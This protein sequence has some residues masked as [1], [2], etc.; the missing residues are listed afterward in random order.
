PNPPGFTTG[1]YQFFAS[2][3]ATRSG[4]QHLAMLVENTPQ[5]IVT[6]KWEQDALS[7]IGYHFVFTDTGLS[8]T[9]PNFNG[10]VQ[11]MKNAGVTGV[12]FQATGQILGQLANAMNQAG[13]TL[14]F[15]NYVSTAYDPAFIQTAGPGTAG[16]VLEQQ[17]AMYE[18]QDAAAVP[19][20][21]TFDQWYSRVNPGQ[22]PDIYAAYGWLA[23]MLFAEGLNAGGAP[24][25]PALLRGLQQITSFNGAGLAAPSDPVTK[26]PPSCWIAIDVSNGKFVRD[27]ATPSGFRCSPSGYYREPG[28]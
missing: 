4:T 24:T 2:N 26:T 15:G 8:P 22:T 12:I 1:P 13:M 11:K 27:P 17:L 21:A 6:G 9:D 20:V 25:R 3:P 19:M 14:T 5:T 18:G 10:D 16:T 23:G 28:T 7:S